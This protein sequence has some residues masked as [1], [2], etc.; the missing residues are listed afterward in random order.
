MPF[1]RRLLLVH[2]LADAG[3]QAFP[4]KRLSADSLMDLHEVSLPI[5]SFF[6]DLG[7]QS[8]EAF[9]QRHHMIA[10]GLGG[11]NMFTVGPV[12][13]RV[14]RTPACELLLQ[15]RRV[16]TPGGRLLHKT[17]VDGFCKLP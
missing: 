13:D 8:V 4:P 12:Q 10:M 2:A 5:P 17:T 16:R 14:T 7:V 3:V 9:L 6:H 1:P 15:F 11:H